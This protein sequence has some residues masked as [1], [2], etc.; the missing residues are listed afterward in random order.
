[1]T[2][3]RLKTVR[4][5]ITSVCMHFNTLALTSHICELS[6]VYQKQTTIQR[7]SP[8]CN[9][10]SSALLKGKIMLIVHGLPIMGIK[11]M[12]FWFPAQSV[13]HKVLR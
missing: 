4:S 11:P 13:N 2:F 8:W 1:M 9:L 10:R 5:E 3:Y 7:Q 12:T 6:N